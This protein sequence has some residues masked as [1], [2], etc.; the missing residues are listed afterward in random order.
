MG[1]KTPRA[2]VEIHAVRSY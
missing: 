2:E 1:G